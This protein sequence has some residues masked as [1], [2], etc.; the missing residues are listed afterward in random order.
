MMRSSLGLGWAVSVACSLMLL[1][2]CDKLKAV[3]D[4]MAQMASNTAEIDSLK[5]SLADSR[6]E[7]DALRSQV[8]GLYD[9]V[10]AVEAVQATQATKAPSVPPS[11]T[12][13][14][15]QEIGKRSINYALA[16]GTGIDARAEVY[17]STSSMF[18]GSSAS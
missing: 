14:G 1:S 17:G 3:D 10:A 9:R 5:R 8:I 13:L 11:P 6:K 16:R 12:A 7:T 4:L 2:G 18:Q 15:P